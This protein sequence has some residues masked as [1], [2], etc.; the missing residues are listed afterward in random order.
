L[1]IQQ[2][3]VFQGTFITC[4]CCQYLDHTLSACP[5]DAHQLSTGTKQVNVAYQMPRN[6][7]FKLTYNLGWWN[8][9][10]FS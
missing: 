3:Q 7:T 5:Y 10:N 4:S 2:P 8:H 6:D 1:T 9:P